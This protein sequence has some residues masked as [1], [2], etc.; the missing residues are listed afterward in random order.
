MLLEDSSI[1][2]LIE[3][4]LK[5]HDVKE[6]SREGYRR[7]LRQF[8]LWCSA[9][10]VRQPDREEII[11]YKRYLVDRCRS[12]YT[13]SGYLVPVR[14]FFAWTETVKLYPN[15]SR[16]IKG[17]R[18]QK[19]F[20]RDPLTV[21]QVNELLNSIDRTTLIGKRDFALLN[22]LARTGLRTIE[23]S[24]ADVGDRRQVGGET[25][26]IVQGKGADA[27]DEIVVLV[28]NTLQPIM[29]YV[30][31]R[32]GTK[33]TSPLFASVGDGNRGA[34]L[35]TRTIRK[36]VK[37]RLRSIGVD[38]PRLTSHSFRHFMVTSALQAGV[39]LQ[40]VQQAARHTSILSTMLYAHNIN[41]ASGVAEKAL[42]KFIESK[43]TSE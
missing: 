21:E 37:E 2:H 38:S 7:R 34:R 6:I 27:K 15:I 17:V 4:F 25:I 26:L 8:F 23:V 40:E 35:S 11:D 36:I 39:P 22:L 24:R 9:N 16:G 14:Q 31:A 28:E 29:D 18:R 12:A 10:Q 1:E 19:G 5:A 13:I 30:I 33:P 3:S 42:D 43:K 20:C 41:R 32:N